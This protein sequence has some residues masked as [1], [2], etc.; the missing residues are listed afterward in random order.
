MQISSNQDFIRRSERRVAELEAE[1]TAESGGARAVA[2][3][4]GRPQ[5]RRIGNFEKVQTLQEMANQL[6]EE[7]GV[8]AK[9][10]QGGET[11]CASGDGATCL[12]NAHAG[13]TTAHRVDGRPSVRQARGDVVRESEDVVGVDIFASSGRRETRRDERR[14][15]A[16]M[17]CWRTISGYG[18]RGP[19]VGEATHP[20]P[21]VL[22]RNLLKRE[23]PCG[24]PAPPRSTVIVNRWRPVADAP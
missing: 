3:V 21:S 15:G 20:G 5:C 11:V 13:P 10:V 18:Y 14:Q 17:S 23:G 24:G 19:R 2:P 22:R 16:L 7:R 4:G 9:E 8:L 1:R 6:Q 12:A